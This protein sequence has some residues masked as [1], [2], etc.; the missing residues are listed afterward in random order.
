MVTF[1][2]GFFK[3]FIWFSGRPKVWVE[4]SFIHKNLKMDIWQ[5]F[6]CCIDIIVK[7]CVKVPFG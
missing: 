3:I 2:F 6:W 1:D 4:K 7:Q 5:L